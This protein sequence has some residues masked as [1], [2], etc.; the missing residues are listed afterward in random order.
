MRLGFAKVCI[1][2][3]PQ[4]SRAPSSRPACGTL[5]RRCPPR[6]APSRCHWLQPAD[7][8][9][10]RSTAAAVSP[11]RAC[12]TASAPKARPSGSPN[13]SWARG[14]GVLAPR[15]PVVPSAALMA[16]RAQPA[17]RPARISGSDSRPAASRTVPITSS[18]SCEYPPYPPDPG[19]RCGDAQRGVRLVGFECPAQ[20]GAQVV[21][22]D[23]ESFEPHQLVGPSSTPTSI[24]LGKHAPGAA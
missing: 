8:W 14:A 23:F 4:R 20:R 16:K 22:L 2:R 1:R 12:M 9:R 15:D 10:A 3:P 11:R 13:C 17:R 18:D 7:S 24:R 6:P 19:Q 21:V 5:A